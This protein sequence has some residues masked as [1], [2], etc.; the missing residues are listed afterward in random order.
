MHSINQHWG[1]F[2]NSLTFVL[3]LLADSGY[4][5]LCHFHLP[6]CVIRQKFTWYHVRHSLNFTIWA[7]MHMSQFTVPVTRGYFSSGLYAGVLGSRNVVFR[8]LFAVKRKASRVKS[9]ANVSF[10]HQ[11]TSSSVIWCLKITRHWQPLLGRT[12]ANLQ[13]STCRWR[14]GEEDSRCALESSHRS[15]PSPGSGQ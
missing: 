3:Q 9:K 11:A 7:S 6:Q 4:M 12:R 10:H 13:R 8:T 1:L 5:I 14:W 15:G 2:N